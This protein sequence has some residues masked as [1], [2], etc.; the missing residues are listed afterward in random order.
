MSWETAAFVALTAAGFMV[1]TAGSFLLG[2]AIGLA[3]GRSK[4]FRQG[5]EA[6]SA[7]HADRELTGNP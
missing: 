2:L 1:F 3:H 5:W 6:A 4:G 7:N